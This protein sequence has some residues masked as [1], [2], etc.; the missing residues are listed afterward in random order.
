MN[1]VLVTGGAGYIGSHVCKSLK[2]SGWLPVSYDN[3]TTG[4]SDFVKWGPCVI[5]DI[6]NKE[7]LSSTIAEYNPVAIIH[8]AASA[9]VGESV[10]DPQKYYTNNIVNSIGLIDV[11]VRHNIKNI[12]FSSSC[13]TYGIPVGGRI[14][15]TN[16]QMPI[17]PYGFTKLVIERYLSD[18]SKVNLINSVALR[19][20]NAAGADPDCE[21]GELHDPETHLIPLCI[22]AA[23]NSKSVEIFG[24]DYPTHDGTAVRDY[25]H[26]TDLANAHVQ[27]IDFLKRN[28]GFHAF[29]LGTGRGYSVL[30]ILTELKAVGMCVD[31]KIADRRQG[32][33]PSL[34][35]DPLEAN[36]VLGWYPVNSDLKTIIE[37][38]I[39]W[40]RI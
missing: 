7:L 18:L 40:H 14:S 37:T 6:E 36:Q 1:T 20:F 35:A 39:K 19:F 25:I 21:V 2:S 27:A 29:N 28:V 26:V 10:T 9:Y 23:L 31:Y 15:S 33:P 32:D 11:A 3:L 22:S 4:H 12:I 34:V 24:N 16:I 38:A 17:N 13:A 30:E 8:L 5:G